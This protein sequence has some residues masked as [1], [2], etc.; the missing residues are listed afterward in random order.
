[1]KSLLIMILAGGLLTGTLFTSDAE[2]GGRKKGPKHRRAEVV[3]QYRDAGYFRGRDVAVIRAYYRP[4]R[5]LPPGLRHQY[6]RTGHLPPGWRKRMRPIP[7]Y[8]ERN[9]VVLPRGYRRGVIDGHVVVYRPSGA[10]ID[11]AVVF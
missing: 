6:S 5:W 9:L 3:Y 4:Y 10:I 8:I 11:V 1:M 2:A 7:V